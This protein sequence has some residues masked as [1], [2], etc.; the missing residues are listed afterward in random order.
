MAL[1]HYIK[2]TLIKQ[3]TQRIVQLKPVVHKLIT[4]INQDISNT[5][6]REETLKLA[7]T[8]SSTLRQMDSDVESLISLLNN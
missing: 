1:N 5:Y 6:D 8:L 7:E 2:E 4:S 3:N